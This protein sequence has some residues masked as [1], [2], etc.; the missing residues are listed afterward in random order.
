MLV[1]FG[2][3]VGERQNDA[4]LALRR[5][6]HQQPFYGLI[7][8][9]PAYA[10]LAVFYDPVQVRLH[11]R[12]TSKAAD[13]IKKHLVQ[14]LAS[15]ELNT[16]AE[17]GP[18]IKIPVYYNGV[19]LETISRMHN[20]PVEEIIRMH[21]ETIVKVY[22]IGFLP[23]FAY[24]GKIDERIATP[25]LDNPRTNVQAGTVGI[26][27]S[28]TGIYPLDS[29]GGWQLLGQTP[30]KIFDVYKKDPCLLKAGDRIQFVSIDKE[31]FHELN[32]Y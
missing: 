3:E 18:L 17:P 13:S 2:N 5:T 9:V 30:I 15:M 25:R 29:P 1:S 26:A 31:I 8:C 19:D 20:R 27:G 32:E 21:T 23:G 28:Q 4:V 10:S 24:M 11:D 22:M 6:L 7:E 16:N 12:S 14:L